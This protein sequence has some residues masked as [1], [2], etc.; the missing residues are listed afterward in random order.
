MPLVLCNWL[1]IRTNLAPK[2]EPPSIRVNSYLWMP[3]DTAIANLVENR[4]VRLDFWLVKV[5]PFTHKI[6]NLIESR[7]RVRLCVY[8]NCVPSWRPDPV[9]SEQLFQTIITP[10]YLGQSLHV[11]PLFNVECQGILADPKG[12]AIWIAVSLTHSLCLSLSPFE[13]DILRTN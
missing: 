2:I 13:A 9:V 10:P 11:I 12:Q 7:G 3:F 6:N 8:V 1:K 5:S 4:A